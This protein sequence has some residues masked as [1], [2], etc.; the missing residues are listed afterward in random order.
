MWK[1]L[2]S[3][4]PFTPPL[5]RYNTRPLSS[6]VQ[7][8]RKYF[9]DNPYF[10]VSLGFVGVVLVFG[11]IVDSITR[12]KKVTANIYQCLPPRPCHSIVP[13]YSPLLDGSNV[14]LTG[15]R[16]SG[17]TTL[18]YST[19]ELFLQQWSLWNRK[20]PRVFY[21]NGS[22]KE[23][24]IISLRECLL[25]YGLTDADI[26]PKGKL[27]HH[28]PTAEQLQHMV[29]S[30][31]KKLSSTKSRWMMIIDNINKDTTSLC[32]PLASSLTDGRILAVS[33][34]PSVAVTLKQSVPSLHHVSINR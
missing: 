10:V 25:S 2:I 3:R 23:S 26:L 11:F 31:K 13:L 20:E 32:E 22:D 29:S 14:L 18:A 6:Y 1:R 30:L 21:I 19:S 15:P 33:H 16:G 24:F 17:K 34:D 12:K 9:N 4:Y 28:L 5:A 7:R 27:F 8:T